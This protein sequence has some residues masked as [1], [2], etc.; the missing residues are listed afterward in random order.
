MK[1]RHEPT[2]IRGWD[3]GGRKLRIAGAP[4][5]E[6]WTAP[7]NGEDYGEPVFGGSAGEWPQGALNE[8]S[9]PARHLGGARGG[10][11]VHDLEILRARRKEVTPKYSIRRVQKADT[12]KRTKSAPAVS[13]VPREKSRYRRTAL[14]PKITP[15]QMKTKPTTSFHRVRAGFRMAGTTCFMNSCALR[16]LRCFHTP[17]S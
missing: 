6:V 4:A 5:P 14:N 3:A 15:K 17:T 12:T 8:A 10:G 2:F 11:F 7:S 13:G 1:S 9:V 16:T